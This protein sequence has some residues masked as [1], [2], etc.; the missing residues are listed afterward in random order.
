MAVHSYDKDTQREYESAAAF[1]A[2]LDAEAAR[3]AQEMYRREAERNEANYNREE[4]LRIER[5]EQ[6]RQT[7]R[8][9]EADANETIAANLKRAGKT[10][11]KG[12]AWGREAYN[13]FIEFSALR[14]AGMVMGSLLSNTAA[15][16]LYASSLEE[17]RKA[18]VT[19]NTNDT[20]VVE[21]ARRETERT[22]QDYITSVEDSIAAHAGA[23][24]TYHVEYEETRREAERV[25]A[26]A[27]RAYE[28]IKTNA[29]AAI[30]TA[31]DTYTKSLSS[32]A[33]D[34]EMAIKA[35][36]TTIATAAWERDQE[37]RQITSAHANG[38][39]VTRLIDT[40]Q[41]T[42]MTAEADAHKAYEATVETI[43]NGG[44][45]A[46]TVERMMESAAQTR[47]LAIET[48]S[49]QYNTEVREIA[50]THLDAESASAV[51]RAIATSE[52]TVVRATTEYENRSAQIEL[53]RKHAVET[54]RTEIAVQT[55]RIADAERKRDT[56]ISHQN[57]IIRTSQIKRDDA[58]AVA[59]QTATNAQNK[60]DSYEQSRDGILTA[61]S[62]LQR[63]LNPVEGRQTSVTLENYARGIER[64]Q[65]HIGAE[66]AMR[67]GTDEEKHT[68]AKIME[69][70]ADATPQEMAK[71]RSI[72]MQY[73]GDITA[74]G[75]VG[76]YTLNAAT[77]A[78]LGTDSERKF[79]TSVLDKGEAATAEEK[80][81]VEAIVKKY[82]PEMAYDFGT[83]GC[84]DAVASIE[85]FRHF[86]EKENATIAAELQTKTSK[87]QDVES[88][89]AVAQVSIQKLESIQ[90]QLTSGKGAD[91]NPL[92][93]G[94]IKELK[95]QLGKASKEAAAAAGEVTR[96]TQQKNAIR[97]SI[98]Q[99][100]ALQS[101]NA[102]LIKGI[103]AQTE[104]LK[105]SGKAAAL[106]LI[107]CKNKD[108]RAMKQAAF[109]EAKWGQ[110]KGKAAIALLKNKDQDVKN[111][112]DRSNKK[113]NSSID[114]LQREHLRTINKGDVFWEEMNRTTVQA[115]MN[116]RKFEKAVAIA[117]YARNITSPMAQ[118]FG[119]GVKLVGKHTGFTNLTEKALHSN[120]TVGGWVDKSRAKQLAK[121]QKKIDEA[122]KLKE[123]NE[124]RKAAGLKPLLSK[125]E[126]RIKTIGNVINLPMTIR[127][128]P[129]EFIRTQATK[130]GKKATNKIGGAIGKTRL[131]KWA[132]KTFSPALQAMKKFQQK[133]Q[134]F[135][136]MNF[137]NKV[138]EKIIGWIMS[139]LSSVFSWVGTLAGYV[140]AAAGILLLIVIVV[141]LVVML[142]M[143]A[144]A[145]ILNFFQKMGSS[146]QALVKHEPEFMLEQAVNY[147]NSELE[148]LELFQASDPDVLQYW[149]LVPSND[150]FYVAMTYN[151][152][153]TV[154][155]SGAAASMGGP[156][157][158]LEPY[159]AD[160]MSWYVNTR[161]PNI[162]TPTSTT[163]W[164]KNGSGQYSIKATYTQNT[165]WN[166]TFNFSNANVSTDTL[167]G[168]YALIPTR[169][170]DNISI[171]YYTSEALKSGNKYG[172]YQLVDN[173]SAYESKFEISNAKD[174]LSVTDAVYTNKQ[175]TMQRFEV[176][177][178]LGV[179]EYQLAEATNGQPLVN[180]FWATHKPIYLSGNSASDVWYHA[181]DPATGS[182]QIHKKW[183]GTTAP[184]D[185]DNEHQILIE[186]TYTSQQMGQPHSGP[187]I[188]CKGWGLKRTYSSYST[189]TYHS[190]S[191]FYH[192]QFM[193]MGGELSGYVLNDAKEYPSSA[194]RNAYKRAGS[195][196][197]YTIYLKLYDTGYWSDT[198]EV[199][200]YDQSKHLGYINVSNNDIRGNQYFKL[201]WNSAKDDYTYRT[202]KT[203]P[204]G[205]ANKTVYNYKL[206]PDYSNG[207]YKC[208][209]DAVV[210]SS[211]NT[212]AKTYICSGHI[213]LKMAMIVSSIGGDKTAATTA[214]Q[215]SFL[216]DAAR[217]T[218]VPPGQS[219]GNFLF[220]WDTD[221][222][223]FGFGD[224]DV[225]PFDPSVDLAEGSQI[226]D[227]A[228]AKAG[229]EDEKYEIKNDD[230]PSDD[231]K[232]QFHTDGSACTY[233]S[234]KRLRKSPENTLLF[235]MCFDG[236]VFYVDSY[237]SGEQKNMR[238]Y[239][240]QSNSNLNSALN[241]GSYLS[242]MI[243][244]GTGKPYVSTYKQP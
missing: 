86:L 103:G 206:T 197:S 55:N 57:D 190:K 2:Q 171:H 105:T 64:V 168:I 217:V 76:A 240:Q 45:D 189:Y 219:K 122:K 43:R 187:N 215:E 166:Q 192:N 19:R 241:S 98:N 93:E 163:F 148:I 193:T 158:W 180:L 104:R 230:D 101:R 138:K 186:Q 182:V 32:I 144:L 229:L 27:T 15:E 204:S 65:I 41:T 22:L 205:T 140:L 218:P 8:K 231:T 42:R 154:L 183:D 18:D 167:K 179:G 30:R 109:K 196:Y 107:V 23:K 14:N 77:A 157:A 110:G 139:I 228:S 117:A 91:G 151:G 210:K 89:I 225:E 4:Q 116:K 70:G 131:G 62:S 184:L 227:L 199:F 36:D 33:R 145:A 79:I 235:G 232:T 87:L 68:V 75:M 72:S 123:E 84:R 102:E 243:H 17:A 209:C 78:K 46:A 13:T 99:M 236:T 115:M 82:E 111:G 3:H 188:D 114:K 222:G 130:L 29:D 7:Q 50:T 242:F 39:E 74:G 20:S 61:A 195:G 26:T 37:I 81:Q 49:K 150:P 108:A 38:A 48:A 159:N 224:V 6:R 92:T 214:K 126:K 53:E 34:T 208:T 137:L 83:T 146:H 121:Q 132:N 172:N 149:N 238:Y 178:Y 152:G 10:W 143:A 5:E 94:Q 234:F 153:D 44:H 97:A 177:A 59:S 216:D 141:L 100:T 69:K 244:Q 63:A 125:E 135:N 156:Y 85:N 25:Q 129:K 198:Y 112:I 226:R 66:I 11:V 28:T 40:A 127:N 124:K 47:D 221:T 96:L 21:A 113:F 147:R 176:L 16:A 24:A 67:M 136:P 134:K 170:Y 12:D 162:I 133:L 203:V 52:A 223:I 9:R 207:T 128:K 194:L 90:A 35:R 237:Y 202:V 54:H 200:N 201:T 31:D 56:V 119:K 60:R 181:T 239:Y 164:Q 213:D 51:H 106:Q 80:R 169:S 88:R 185:C 161:M 155:Q 95:Q 120:K 233:Y 173:Y 165:Y 58:I 73:A 174:A 220:T 211:T 191:L 175:D 71:L 118:G 212:T 142:I 160:L 1:R